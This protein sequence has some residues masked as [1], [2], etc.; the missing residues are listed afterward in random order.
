MRNKQ[1]LCVFNTI[2][3]IG[4]SNAVT[5]VDENMVGLITRQMERSKLES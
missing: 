3:T 4:N 5:T 2:Y 1:G